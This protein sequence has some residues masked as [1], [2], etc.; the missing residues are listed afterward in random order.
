M[1]DPGSIRAENNGVDPATIDKRV[2]RHVTGRVRPYYAITAPGFE[3]FCRRELTGL[4]FDE[5]DM[6]VDSGGVGFSGR[7]VDCQRANL[8]VRTATRILMRIDR[9]TATNR[10]QLK[11]YCAAVPWELFL[12][13]GTRPGVKV[14]S[15][16]SRLYHS[17]A[18]A[19]AVGEA[20]AMHWGR[21]V[22]RPL[23]HPPQTVFVRL[24]NDR[25][26]LSLDSSGTALYK[27]GL[28]SGPAR[29]PLR[30][31]Q[32]AAILM[33]AG[34]DPGRPLADPLCGAG[35]FS[36]EA[37]MMAKRMAPGMR[38]TFAFEDWPAFSPGQWA[39]LKRE[40]GA[41]ERPLDRPSIFASDIDAG[42]CE[43]LHQ[44]IADN[45]LADAVQV[46]RRDVFACEAGQYG[47]VPGLVAIN[48]P[49]GVRIGS[50]RQAADL[51]QRICRHL[52][53]A[54]RGW[55]VALIAPDRSLIRT[56]PF[57]VRQVPLVHGG[58]KLAMLLGTVR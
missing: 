7:F 38:R 13:R 55:D 18:V 58:L 47:E 14:S 51:F 40:A 41:G 50:A 24:I 49:Y 57:P 31:T 10:R 25:V 48:P 35:T 3:D 2:R 28:K 20:I 17:D 32:A 46:T 44:R 29:A 52:K 19:Q 27:R 4:G 42:A 54:F 12:P 45:G 34:Y 43:G 33:A 22:T 36:L 16:R 56:V 21:A 15:Q 39:F 6:S 26:T 9:F 8:H 1:P 11:K 30:E 53:A 5:G 37:A 23:S